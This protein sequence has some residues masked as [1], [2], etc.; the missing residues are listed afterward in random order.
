[1]SLSPI[2]R[3]ILS[4]LQGGLSV[5]A[6]QAQKQQDEDQ[7]AQRDA[8]KS[9]ADIQAR[10]DFEQWKMQNEP[11]KTMQETVAD[12]NNPG[13][14]IVNNLQW[15]PPETGSDPNLEGGQ[16]LKMSTANDP[17]TMRLDQRSDEA[18]NK[19]EQAAAR[20]QQQSEIAA[21]R[22]DLA[23]QRLALQQE[24]GGKGGAIQQLTDASGNAQLVRIGDDN[25]AH[26]I[27]LE[28]GTNAQKQEW[29]QRGGQNPRMPKP[30]PS[31]MKGEDDTTIPILKGNGISPDA[32]APGAKNVPPSLDQIPQGEGPVSPVFVDPTT[33]P[34]GQFQGGSSGSSKAAQLQ[35]QAAA[36]IKAGADPA[37]VQAR[38]QQLLGG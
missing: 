19:A 12:P 34:L 36:A 9:A 25:V 7:K 21:Q 22:S 33:K 32:P 24:R 16:W 23:A 13:K 14:N 29:R 17:N 15:Q 30:Q 1:M 28:D 31:A 10:K 3:G 20:L 38:L 37:K 18:A 11:P 8:A 27:T 35:A 5:Y 6:S 2:M 26:P 4:G